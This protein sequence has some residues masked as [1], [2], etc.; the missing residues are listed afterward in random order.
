[1]KEIRIVDMAKHAIGM[2]N[3]DTFT[4][5]GKEC[6]IS[7]RNYYSVGPEGD[8]DWDDFVKHGL[9]T[10]NANERGV[11]YYLT[12]DGIN[13]LQKE[14]GIIIYDEDRPEEDYKLGKDDI[15]SIKAVWRFVQDHNL[16]SW[17]MTEKLDVGILIEPDQMSDFCKEYLYDVEEEIPSRTTV[18]G[19]IINFSDLLYVK[20]SGKQM[21]KLRPTE[22]MRNGL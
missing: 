12:Q 7:Y 1:M 2:S 11:T 19:T 13:W 17:N 8:S 22:G 9:A 20:A 4:K 5:Y 21:W 18:Y 3:K 6:F 10:R 16:Y 14:T 15:E